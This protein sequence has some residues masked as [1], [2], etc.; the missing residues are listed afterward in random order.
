MIDAANLKVSLHIEVNPDG[1]VTS[2]EFAGDK[3]RYNSDSFFRAAVDSAIRAVNMA[4]PLKGLPAEK[5]NVRDG[6]R[7][8]YMDFDPRDML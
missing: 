6:W 4:S 8:M 3:G 7:E 2:V 1:S 5:Y